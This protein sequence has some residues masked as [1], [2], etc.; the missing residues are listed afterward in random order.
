MPLKGNG[1][2]NQKCLNIGV[3]QKMSKILFRNYVKRHI[4]A[5]SQEDARLTVINT[6]MLNRL[7]RKQNGMLVI[8]PF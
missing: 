6:Y 1:N 3:I 7:G 4:R 5:V 8:F 2:M